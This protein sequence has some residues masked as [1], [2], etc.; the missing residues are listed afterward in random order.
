[1]SSA[2]A[3]IPDPGPMEQHAEFAVDSNPNEQPMQDHIDIVQSST[4]NAKASSRSEKE[5]RK[6]KSVVGDRDSAME[7]AIEMQRREHDL[8]ENKIKFEEAE[9]QK[10][11]EVFNLQISLLTKLNNRQGQCVTA[12]T[13]TGNTVNDEYN[14]FQVYSNL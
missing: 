13:D 10:K 5:K 3:V 12:T 6:S 2:A 7:S 14:I 9:H 11:M 1:M 8:L 4:S